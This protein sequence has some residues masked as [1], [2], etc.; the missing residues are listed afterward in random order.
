MLDTLSNVK[1]RLGITTS[2]Y[3]TFLTQQITLVSDVIEAYCRRKFLTDSYTQT[4]YSD[5]SIPSSAF[6]LFHYPLS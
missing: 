3:D 4:F 2:D 5:E 6:N 1:N